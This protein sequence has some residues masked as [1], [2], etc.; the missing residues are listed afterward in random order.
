[1]TFRT[2]AEIVA[3]AQRAIPKLSP[4]RGRILS[5][6]IPMVGLEVGDAVFQA[7]VYRHD[8]PSRR[9]ALARAQSS[10]ALVR[11]GALEDAG[12]PPDARIQLGAD[13]RAVRGGVLY[14]VSLEMQIAREKGALRTPDPK[15]RDL[16][17]EGDGLIIGCSS[18]RG[19]WGKGGFGGEHMATVV[20]VEGQVSGSAFEIDTIDG[21]QPGIHGRTR[22]LVWCGPR[23][24]ELWAASLADD[25]SYVFDPADMR[26]TK[27][28]RVL[29]WTDAEALL[30]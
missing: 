14:P 21:G 3:L 9:A 4:A 1:M 23:G 6:L 8:H 20:A 17:M 7:K 25:G 26:P 28:R 30:S 5:A 19:V 16:P 29:A 11:E 10:C 24:D 27:G 15:R 2:D 18:G 13:V 22:A 12:L